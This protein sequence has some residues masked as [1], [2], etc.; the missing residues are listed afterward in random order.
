MCQVSSSVWTAQNHRPQIP[1]WTVERCRKVQPSARRPHMT[2]R[3][4][5]FLFDSPVATYSLFLRAVYTWRPP[6][7]CQ[8]AVA[9]SP[10][11]SGN[12]EL[13]T[14]KREM[15]SEAI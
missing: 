10:V 9:R 13:E 7:G 11:Q 14:R 8:E 2:T 5:G 12:L 6:R 3:G 1:Q 4:L 15:C